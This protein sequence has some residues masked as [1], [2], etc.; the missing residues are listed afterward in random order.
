MSSNLISWRKPKGFTL[1]EVIVVI[2]VVG[3]LS[4]ILIPS[5]ISGPVKA[6]DSQRKADLRTLKTKLEDYYQDTGAYP[7]SLSELMQGNPP[8]IKSVPVDPKTKKPYTYNPAPS[9][10]PFT[11]YTLTAILENKNDKEAP[12]GIFTLDSFQ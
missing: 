10:G 3:I 4:L 1:L 11:S 12:G 6:R 5:L 8:Y 9:G 7:A 2:V